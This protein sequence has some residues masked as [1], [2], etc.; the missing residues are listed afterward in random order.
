MSDRWPEPPKL[1]ENLEKLDLRLRSL[2]EMLNDFL[3]LASLEGA[4]FRIERDHVDLRALVAQVAD[5]CGPLFERSRHGFTLES[6]SAEPA[7]VRDH[8]PV[9]LPHRGTEHARPLEELPGGE[10]DDGEVV[11]VDREHAG[12]Q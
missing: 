3:E 4:S 9:V 8:G 1:E 7:V 6:D 10:V 11:V 12:E 2:V 5:E